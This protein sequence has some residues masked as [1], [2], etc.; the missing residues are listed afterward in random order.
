MEASEQFILA[1]VGAWDANGMCYWAVELKGD[2]VGIAGVEPLEWRRRQCWNLY[3][4]FASR[5]W[6]QGLATEAAV[7]AVAVAHE[8]QPAWPVVARVRPDNAPSSRVA[9]RAG[10]QR[11]P[12]L[13]SDG[14]EVFT[15]TWPTGAFR[16]E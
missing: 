5:V 1:L 13:D 8:L 9:L 12:D 2:L 3:Y 6:G 15:S 4:V 7:E 14:F 11:R 16:V 10:L